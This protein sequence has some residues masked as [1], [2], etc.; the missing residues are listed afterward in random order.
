MG[1][2]GY[3]DN[4]AGGGGG[5][6]KDGYVEEGN[7]KKYLFTPEPRRVRFLTVDVTAEDLMSELGLS[8]EEAEDRLFSKV[9]NEQWLMPYGYWEHQIKEIPGKRFFS[10]AVCAGRGRCPMCDDND[11]ERANGVGENKLLP[12]PVRKRFMVPAY[13]YDLDVVLFVVG[14]EEFFNDI[15]TYVNKHGSASDF[16]IYKVGKGLNTKYKSTFVG[17][18]DDRALPDDYPSPQEVNMVVDEAELRRRIEG[19]R[20]S[21]QAPTA[22]PD[23]Q[24]PAKASVPSNRTSDAGAF[25]VTFGTHKGKTFQQLFD[26]GETEYIEFLAKNSAGQVQATAK[27]FLEGV[28]G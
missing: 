3:N 15:A 19:G 23:G 1:W 8:R 9:A 16:E 13:V 10:T 22:Q 14:N 21:R 5:S 6:N 20:P 27:A 24:A 4:K 11:R 26:L 28:R 12:Y 17:P 18:S 2:N 7:V 25:E